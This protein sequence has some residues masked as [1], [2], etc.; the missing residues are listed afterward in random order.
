VKIA[1]R[2]ASGQMR[3]DDLSWHDGI[4]VEW[5]FAP[6]TRGKAAWVE[7]SLLLYPEQVQAAERRP[8]VIRCNGARRL[9]VA[10]DVAELKDNLWAGNIVDGYRRRRVLRV[11]VTGGFLE[12][13]ASSF[14][15]TSSARDSRLGRPTRRPPAPTMA[16]IRSKARRTSA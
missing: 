14:V 12:I 15:V 1:R 11:V 13:E 2:L 10:C 9:V 8:V 6:A 3:I 16:T 5:R 7:V 4:L